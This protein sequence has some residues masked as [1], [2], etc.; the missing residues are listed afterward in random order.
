MTT[1]WQRLAGDTGQFAVQISFAADPDDGQ[2]ID[3]EIGLSWG[4]FQIWAQGRN[5][6]AHMAEGERVDSVHWYVLPLIEWFAQHWNPLFHEERLPAK[7]QQASAWAS[8]RETRF[9]PPA[10]EMNDDRASK[11]ERDWQAWWNRHALRS[12]SEGGLF[13]DIVFRRYRDSVE[14]S[15]GRAGSQGMPVDFE[16]A[17]SGP[18]IARLPPRSVAEPLHAVL[19]DSIE[20]LCSLSADCERFEALRRTLRALPRTD[21]RQRRLMWLAGLGVD[22]PTVRRGWRRAKRWLSERPEAT[23]SLLRDS[24]RLPLVINGSCHATLMFGCV[25]PNVQR[26]DVLALADVMI[27]LHSNTQRENRLDS[28]RTFIPIDELNAP[29]WSQGYELADEFHEQL[30]GEFVSDNHVDVDGIVEKLDIQFK[31]VSLSDETI[32]GVAIAGTQHAPGVVWNSNSVFNEHQHGRRFTLAHEMCHLLFDWEA[33]RSL[34]IASGPW[35]P[36]GIERRANAFAA[37]LL[38]PATIVNAA[39]SRLNVPLET[40]EGVSNVA[41][42]MEMSFRATLWHLRNLGFIDETCRDR[43]LEEIDSTHQ[44]D[45]N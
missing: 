11:W 12:S 31:E 33:G 19:S 5:L 17:E 25:S 22:E 20:Y 29:Y 39:I 21:Q 32:R 37:M 13:P 38:M 6:C 44:Q 45:V 15:W 4:S 24:E 14:L 18:G 30:D 3:P 41:H 7:S 35:A 28:I 27:D 34:A 8:L 23:S 43:L 2:G 26:T 9:P 10:I 40:L 36:S 42:R 1:Q 16:F